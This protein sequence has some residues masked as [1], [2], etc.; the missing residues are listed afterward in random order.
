MILKMVSVDSDAELCLHKDA[1]KLSAQL[2]FRVVFRSEDSFKI[3][4][5]A[6]LVS[7]AVGNFVQSGG[8]IVLHR[9]EVFNLRKMYLIK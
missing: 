8:V 6:A 2:L 1:G 7:G 4:I 9:F 3:S 5:Q